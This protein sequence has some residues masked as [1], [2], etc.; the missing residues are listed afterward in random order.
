VTHPRVAEVA[1]VGVP[2]PR[3]GERACAA[4]VASHSPGPDVAELREVLLGRGVAKFKAPER[5]VLYDTLPKNAAGK[6]LKH[7]IKAE[8]TE[9]S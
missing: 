7:H 6:V 4:I 9:E 2:D 1:I 3:T 8:L 5:V